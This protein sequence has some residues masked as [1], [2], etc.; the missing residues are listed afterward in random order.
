MLKVDMSVDWGGRPLS[1]LQRLM[2]K[3]VRQLRET[4][5]DAC[6][7]TAITMLKSLRPL[8]RKAKT[9]PKASIH[10][11]IA[12]TGWV[13][14]WKSTVGT[15]SMERFFRG[16]HQG[17]NLSSAAYMKRCVRTS[18]YH[19]TVVEGIYPIWLTGAGAFDKGRVVHV[20][21]VTPN[22]YDRM[23]WK[24][25]K[26]S[27]SWYIAAYDQ[28]TAEK[29]ANRLMAKYLKKYSGMA[30]YAMTRAM[31]DLHASGAGSDRVSEAA[32]KV[33]EGNLRIKSFGGDSE[34]TVRV[35][36]T[37]AYAANAFTRSDAVDYAMAK[38][39]NSIAGMLRKRAGDIF[40]PSL[41]T[42][43]PEIAGHRRKGA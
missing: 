2:E 35:D 23:L 25:N 14:G 22:H 12:D 27:G 17:Q 38:A 18:R 6:I 43:F 20:Y 36:D 42:P 15:K 34:W 9:A 41:E 5:R 1:E 16:V 21:R 26:H 29:H 30:R 11:T 31:K 24:Q 13:G 10:Y 3:R 7:A 32:K 39:A 37:L 8:V 4:P 28:K 19:G 40:D 33:V